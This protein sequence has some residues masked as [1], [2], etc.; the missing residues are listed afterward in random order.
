MQ[1]KIN[2]V[3]MDI[4]IGSTVEDAIKLSKA[5]YITGSAIALIEGRE[6]LE[7]HVNKYSIETTGGNI[8]IELV[9]TANMLTDFW[10]NNYKKFIGTAIRWTTSH[11]VAIGSIVSDL[12]PTN[13]EHLY[14]RGDVIIS[15]SSFS[16]EST[17]I[18][19]SKV[20]HEGI[21][22]VPNQNKGVF[23][24]VVGG[25]RNIIKL[26]NT[27]EVLDIHPVIERKS[28]IKSAA[29]TDFNTELKQGN[30]LYTYIEVEANPEAPISFEHFLKII[31]DGTLHVDYE[32]ES[33]IGNNTLKGLE[34]DTELIE[35]RKRGVV[36]LRNQ[37][38]GVGRVYIYREDRVSVPT[39]NIIGHVTRGIQILDTVNE[40]DKITIVTNPEK[41]STVA[42]TQKEADDYLDKL[43][44]EHE[45][46]GLTDDDAIIVAQDPLYTI[47]VHKENK[48]KT[49]GVPKED[50]VE[51]ELYPEESPSSVWYFRKISGLLNGDVGH[52]QVNMAIKEMN[53]LMFKAV[54]KE[55]KGLIPEK[56]PDG[57]VQAWEICVSNT[58]CKHVGNIG[59]RFI[60]NTE[61]G[62]TGESFS[63]TNII[64]RVVGG[65]DNLK[66][67]KE[68]DTVYVKER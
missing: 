1:V 29:V 24:T 67:F 32:S 23:A 28:I 60:D 48:L 5:P 26:K 6:E 63:S 36:T 9:D 52:L 15:L 31:E 16:N 43:G 4:P 17:H 39:H 8:I 19:I 3:E 35:K 42:L 62:P 61:F 59:I 18:I 12:E 33:F 2:N 58:A 49:L 46:D 55:A 54:N 68:G 64:G 34:K 30:E 20:K 37:G 14:N 44:I 40:H 66:A 53:I 11:E 45:R 57:K 41:I 25:K 22:G 65:F 27:D 7:S 10:K 50:F 47:D 56:L 51:I 21:Y 13:E 38:A